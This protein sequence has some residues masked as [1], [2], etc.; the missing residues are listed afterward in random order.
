MTVL[1][2]LLAHLI[3]DFWLQTDQMVRSKIKYIKRHILHHLLTTGIVLVILWGYQYE[4]HHIIG[5]F[6]FPLLFICFT[7]LFIDL[8]KI[9]LVDS[10]K[11]T[12]NDHL[13]KLGFFLFDQVLHV[14]MILVSCTLFFQMSVAEMF[15]SLLNLFG[16]SSLSPIKML[17]FVV[18]IFIL[19]TSVSGHIVK[20]IVG[21]LPSELANFEGE[22]TLRSQM[23]EAKEKIQPKIEN[24]FTEEYHYFTY[25]TP[26]RSRGK[27][28]GYLERL[29]IIVLTVIGAYPSIAF[30]IAAKSI[31]R[32]KQLDD[33]NWAE[34]FLLGT[35]SSIFLGLVLGLLVQGIIM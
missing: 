29:L 13:K 10:I 9:K 32:F 8:L 17:L 34:Y 21:S 27:L 26:L 28:I 2:L 30:I 16:T 14:V 31:A 20:F 25:S 5:Y 33:R 7:H 22:L 18:V 24:S 6:I 1:L 15:A 23:I 12:G 11:P 19:A 4:F 35:L 3:A